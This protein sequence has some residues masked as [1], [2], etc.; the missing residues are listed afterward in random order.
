MIS[1]RNRFPL[2]VYCTEEE[3]AVIEQQAKTAGMSVSEYLRQV[4]MGMSIKSCVDPQAVKE[5]ARVNADLGR[6]G[7]LLKMLLSNDEK[8]AS[9]PRAQLKELTSATVREIAKTQAELFHIS[10]RILSQRR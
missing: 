5:L 7:G 2:Q 3:Q 1:R 10:Q 8:L 6:A 4:G 9:Y